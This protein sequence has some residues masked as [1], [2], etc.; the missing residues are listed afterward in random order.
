MN[1]PILQDLLNQ[2]T[3]KFTL[4]EEGYIQLR[5][6]LDLI[7]IDDPIP[8]SVMNGGYIEILTEHGSD[9]FF[10][11][12]S[13]K[14]KLTCTAYCNKV[15]VSVID[16]ENVLRTTEELDEKYKNFK[17][18]GNMTSQKAFPIT[19][20]YFNF[21]FLKFY[22]P[23]QYALLCLNIITNVSL[24]LALHNNH[25]KVENQP[26][27]LQVKTSDSLAGNRESRRKAKK[28]MPSS[29][30]TVT[31]NLCV[32]TLPDSNTIEK[33]IM[34]HYPISKRVVK[35]HNRTLRNGNVKFFPEKTYYK[36]K[37]LQ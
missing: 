1:M 4:T 27:T 18:V 31:R 26:R 11:Q 21:E 30:V 35:A 3:K 33:V 9:L 32:S 36:L 23:E 10:I 2:A 25:V 14:S 12:F 16:I 37:Q 8:F 34:S 28:N 7:F 17:L 6:L 15:L 5:S 22:Q 29:Y 13:S 20:R 19:L 24:Y